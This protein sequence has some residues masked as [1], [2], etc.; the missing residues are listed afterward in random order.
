MLFRSD[1]FDLQGRQVAGLVDGEME[2]GTH[3]VVWQATD[4]Q[5]LPLPSGVYFAGLRAGDY[6]ETRKLMLV[7]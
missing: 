5:G 1:I 6:A 3:R 4:R 7:R 2:V